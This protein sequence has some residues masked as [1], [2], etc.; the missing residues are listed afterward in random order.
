MGTDK[1]RLQLNGRPLLACVVDTLLGVLDD[2]VVC[3]ADH[4]QLVGIDLPD[5]V[6]VA[7]DDPAGHGPLAGLASGLRAARHDT[8]FACAADLPLLDAHTVG[9]LCDLLDQPGRTRLP[10]AVIPLV[11]D[12]LQVLHAAYRRTALAH[13]EQVLAAG[14]RALRDLARELEREG[15]VLIVDEQAL[16]TLGAHR[17]S[18]TNVNTPADLVAA[19]SARRA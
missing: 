5:D 14:H 8:V 7:V 12:R 9:V 11:D 18:F 13:V 1:I 2:V 16:E 10:D 19:L 17:A 15:Q 3:V 6:R 4:E